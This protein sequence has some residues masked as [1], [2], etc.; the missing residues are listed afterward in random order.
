MAITQETN[1]I[2]S[3]CAARA[4]NAIALGGEPTGVSSPRD[5]AL[6]GPDERPRYLAM[7]LRALLEPYVDVEAD[8]TGAATC[9][10]VRARLASGTL[11]VEGDGTP[12]ERLRAVV[13]ACWAGVDRG[14]DPAAVEQQ[15]W[16]ELAPDAH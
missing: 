8:D 14:E 12:D 11:E 10:G 4:P 7:D 3:P 5:V 15:V 16:D 9:G 2:V 6:A 13:A 1:E